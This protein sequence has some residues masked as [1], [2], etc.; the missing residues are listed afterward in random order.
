M[1]D[2]SPS[3]PIIKTY[4][5]DIQRL[6][7]QQ[8]SHELGMRGPFQ[9][10]LDKAARCQGRTLITEPPRAANA[11]ATT[12]SYRSDSIG[13][14]LLARIAGSQTAKIATIASTT[15]T[16]TNTSGSHSNCN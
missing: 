10:L 14:T 16:A 12:Y 11:D 15:G 2:L 6:K 8:I 5:G 1:L 7:D 13:F 3:D 4:V 9:N